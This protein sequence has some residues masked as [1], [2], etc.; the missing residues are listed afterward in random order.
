VQMQVQHGNAVLDLH[1]HDFTLGL[2]HVAHPAPS[3]LLS[4][5]RWALL[6]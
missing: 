3:A 2:H 4:S 1:L 5:A 6:F